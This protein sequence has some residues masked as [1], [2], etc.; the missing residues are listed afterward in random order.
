M[1]KKNILQNYFKFPF[2]TKLKDGA[3]YECRLVLKH[4][5]TDTLTNIISR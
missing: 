4:L 5:L 3:G 1:N 2:E